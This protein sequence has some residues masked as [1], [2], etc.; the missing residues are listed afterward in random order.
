MLLHHHHELEW[1]FII[2]E[3]LPSLCV[4]LFSHI[5][6]VF[7]D[8]E[9]S[10]TCSCTC[11][12]NMLCKKCYF[13]QKLVLEIAGFYQMINLIHYNMFKVSQDRQLMWYLHFLKNVHCTWSTSAK[14]FR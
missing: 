2:C 7:K 9:L 6:I 13:F 8:V 12:F 3:V 11:V 5:H 10:F 4:K 14:I 1:N